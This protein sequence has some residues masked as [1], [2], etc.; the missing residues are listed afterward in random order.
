MTVVHKVTGYLRKS[1]QLE[2]EFD[3]PANFLG[4]L[5][6]LAHVPPEDEEAIGCYPI[7][8]G[9]VAKVSQLLGLS[10]NGDL[11][12]WFLEPVEE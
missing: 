12:S 8:N 1:E 7:M 11:Y 10:L 9:S 5:R 2:R 4:R 6:E 3:V